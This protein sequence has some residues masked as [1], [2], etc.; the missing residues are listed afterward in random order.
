MHL[1]RVVQSVAG[2]PLLGGCMMI[3]GLGHTGG[4]AWMDEPGHTV[5]G[6]GATTLQRAE[7]SNNGLTIA[8][9]FPTPSR[10]DTVTID[11]QLL[12][13]R[14]QDQRSDGDVWL[15]I[16]TPD[17]RVDRIRMQRDQVS[18][19]ETFQAQ[20]CFPG[21]GVFLVTA[22]GRAGTGS[23]MR[24]VS[25]TTVAEVGSSTHGVRHDWLLPVAALSGLAWIAMMVV[26]MGSS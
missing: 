8:L 14:S 6:Q 16:Q 11:A 17:R 5:S 12:M 2:V 23:D 15:R 18:A 4:R 24:T 26:M 25:V 9:S 21:A 3:G 7:A 13:E 1:T 22:D 20:Y 10:G 19:K